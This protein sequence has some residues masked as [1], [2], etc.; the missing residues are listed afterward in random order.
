MENKFTPT[1]G[2]IP[3][4]LAGRDKMIDEM[5]I[6]FNGDGSDPNLISLFVGA[7]GTGKTVLLSYLSDIALENG[8]ISIKLSC[9][10]NMLNEAIAQLSDK[11]EEFIE[12][13]SVKRLKSISLGQLIGVE[14][15]NVNTN[16]PSTWTTSV[17]KML[18]QLTAQDTGVLFT[19]D[20]IKNSV[21][22]MTYFMTAYQ[23]FVTEKRKVGLLM[24]GLPF[25]VSK[26]LENS[27]VTF[28]RR[29]F[30]KKLEKIPDGEAANAFEKT[31]VSSGRE[32]D[33]K[34]LKLA[35]E[36]ADGYPYMIQLIG[37]RMLQQNPNRKKV[38]VED[39]KEGTKEARRNMEDSIYRTT[40]RELSKGDLRFIHAML[41]DDHESSMK[42]I[43]ERLNKSK[44]YTSQYRKRLLE[45]GVIRSTS[46]GYVTFTLPGFK[47][48]LTSE[49]QN[50][51]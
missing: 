47:E 23:Y 36:M 46:M 22:E 13:N 1:F 27:D 24:A 49:L 26:L 39:V 8:W 48:F 25:N 45:A 15:E 43:S 18:A 11:T 31:I 30:Y 32:I 16:K 9:T 10:S 14:W 21:K 28:T 50:E 37:Y 41:K 20:E 35:V 17:D 42:D 3:L 19:I 29:A 51:V 5:K 38:S 34:A 4:Y 40:L 2:R 7:R 33:E 6:A 12:T 44:Q